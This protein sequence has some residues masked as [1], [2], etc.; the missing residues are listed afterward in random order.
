MSIIDRYVP[1]AGT[2]ITKKYRTAINAAAKYQSSPSSVSVS[3]DADKSNTPNDST[4]TLHS[5]EAT[6]DPPTRRTP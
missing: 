3:G 5:L 2:S 1:L 6:L 4:G